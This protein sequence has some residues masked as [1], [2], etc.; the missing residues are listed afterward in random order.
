MFL[1]STTTHPKHARSSQAG[2][3]THELEEIPARK[4]FGQLSCPFWKLTITPVGVLKFAHR[5]ANTAPILRLSS[6]SNLTCFRWRFHQLNGGKPNSFH[7]IGSAFYQPTPA[8][9]VQQP[10]QQTVPNPNYKPRFGDEHSREGC[11]GN[12]D[13][14]PY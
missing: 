12:R 4:V 2:R 8:L 7:W 11:G 13:R 6:I 5:L 10:I 9:P 1:R 14:R 3:S